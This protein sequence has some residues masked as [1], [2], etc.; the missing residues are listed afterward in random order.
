MLRVQKLVVEK[1]V[2]VAAAAVAVVVGDGHYSPSE[3]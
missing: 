1:Q 3:P 2:V